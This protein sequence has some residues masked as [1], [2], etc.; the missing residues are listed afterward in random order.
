MGGDRSRLNDPFS[1]QLMLER[2]KDELTRE[3]GSPGR[4]GR[5]PPRADSPSLGTSGNRRSASTRRITGRP[6]CDLGLGTQQVVVILRQP[7]RSS[8]PADR[9]SARESESSLEDESTF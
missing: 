6:R 1:W 8:H 7:P 3:E 4:L 2:T 9:G 5:R